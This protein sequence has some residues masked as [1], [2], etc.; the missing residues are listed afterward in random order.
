M[1][2]DVFLSRLYSLR[3]GWDI[4]YSLLHSVHLLDEA[5]RSSIHWHARTRIYRSI[6]PS[7]LQLFL[8]QEWVCPSPFHRTLNLERDIARV[9]C[10]SHDYFRKFRVFPTP[11]QTWS[12][13]LSMYVS[14]IIFKYGDTR[15]T[16]RTSFFS[17]SRL[18]AGKRTRLFRR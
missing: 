16:D 10:A 12:R 14:R 13:N 1:R 11:A 17:V 2:A 15:R 18:N 5:L 6:Q 3:G 8:P 9:V 7:D 4:D